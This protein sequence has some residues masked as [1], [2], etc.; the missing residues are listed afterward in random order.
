MDTWGE[1]MSLSLIEVNYVE[2]VSTSNYASYDSHMSKIS[3]D[4]F[5]QSPWLGTLESFDP[6]TKTFLADEGTM[7]IMSLEEPPRINTHHH[8]SFLSRPA[9]MSTIWV[10]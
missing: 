1:V 7:E 6:F 5:S 4:M 2:I 10:C 3:L 8:S 9:I